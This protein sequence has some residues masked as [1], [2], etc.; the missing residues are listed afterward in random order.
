MDNA[1]AARKL[2]EAFNRFRKL[3]KGPPTYGG[4]KPSEMGLLMHVLG[5]CSGESGGAKVSELSSRMHVTSPSVTQ[6]VT[7]LEERGLVTRRM[8][9]E[10]RRSVLVSLTDKGREITAQAEA[11]FLAMLSGVVEHLGQEKSLMLANLMGEVFDY[12]SKQNSQ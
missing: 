9:P 8:D 4:L 12:L 2:M 1:E 7:S 3:T 6:L 11:H 5:H 10:D